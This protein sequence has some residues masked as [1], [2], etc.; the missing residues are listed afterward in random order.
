MSEN[1][2]NEL[3]VKRIRIIGIAAGRS[4]GAERSTK[5]YI[6]NGIE[7]MIAVIGEEIEEGL[8]A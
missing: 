6:K 2:N 7:R 8:R 4:G 5:I 1:Y 3:E